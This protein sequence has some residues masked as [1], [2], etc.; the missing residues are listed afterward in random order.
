MA[1]YDD[2]QPEGVIPAALLPFTQDFS[3]D[4]AGARRHFGHLARTDG[5]SA[6][7]VNGHSSEIHACT[8]DDQARVLDIAVEAAGDLPVISGVYSDNTM[9]AARIARMAADHGAS[10]LLIF[11]PHSIG[12]GG[13]QARPEMSRAHLSA[14]ANATDLPL[15]VFQYDGPYA[16]RLDHLVG[17][18]EAIPAIRAIKDKSPP[19]LHE[20]TINTLQSLPRPVNVLTTCSAWLMSSLVMGAKGVLSGSGSIIADLHVAL[21]NAV[22]ADDLT[23]AKEISAR[24][25][26]TAQC[27]YSQPICDQH[28]RMKEALV[29]LGR[30][31][32]PAVV[33]PPLQKLGEAELDRIRAAIDAAGLDAEGA[34]GLGS[35]PVAAE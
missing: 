22:Q 33:R 26:P 27:F 9:E 6:I 19:P 32:G 7:T 11:P 8:I 25:Y 16:Y 23:K 5:L 2:W 29:M 10:A 28:N 20:R 4:A 30:L 3:L 15:I 1:R 21:W 17:H 13:G 24:I 31:D 35:L 12:M 18:C 34:S 14:I